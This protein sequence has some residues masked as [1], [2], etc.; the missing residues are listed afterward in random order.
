MKH[1]AL[2]LCLAAAPVGAE[3]EVLQHWYAGFE[4]DQNYWAQKEIRTYIIES[5]P[6]CAPALREAIARLNNVISKLKF[7]EVLTP[8]VDLWL[9]CGEY[10]FAHVGTRPQVGSTYCRVGA[11]P[12][13]SYKWCIV[14]VSTGREA[15]LVK[16]TAAH[17]LGHVLGLGHY[18]GAGEGKQ[19]M[20]HNRDYTEESCHPSTEA[21]NAL[22]IEE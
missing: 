19:L 7:S 22:R 10:K 2:G 6:G 15:S 9:G 21:L 1:L 14:R 18:N 20:S 17:E 4:P 3:Q 12:D 16:C 8:P 5:V 13:N 11:F